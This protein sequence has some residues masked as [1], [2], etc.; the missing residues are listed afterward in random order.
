[1]SKTQT[2]VTE[3]KLFDSNGRLLHLNIMYE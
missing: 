3:H 2:S 1:M